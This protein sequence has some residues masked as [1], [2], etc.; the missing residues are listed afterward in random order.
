[1]FL[2]SFIMQTLLLNQ[3]SYIHK[4]TQKYPDTLINTL[5]NYKAPIY[6][7]SKQTSAYLQSFR[8]K[9]TP[10]PRNSGQIRISLIHC[11]YDELIKRKESNTIQHIATHASTMKSIA[12]HYNK[13]ELLHSALSNK[14]QFIWHC[15]ACRPDRKKT[16]EPLLKHRAATST[17]IR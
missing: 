14:I 10:P 1:M 13:I 5:N 9:L 6:I 7:A 2:F 17:P 4:R 3:L 16:T 12:V 8:K 11:I 15:I